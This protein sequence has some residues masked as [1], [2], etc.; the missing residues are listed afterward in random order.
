MACASR[1][2]LLAGASRSTPTSRLARVLRLH[3]NLP[4]RQREF[5][6]FITLCAAG[7]GGIATHANVVHAASEMHRT[8]GESLPSPG[9]YGVYGGCNPD[10][11]EGLFDLWVRLRG[12]IKPDST[13]QRCWWEHGCLILLGMSSITTTTTTSFPLNPHTQAKEPGIAHQSHGSS[14]Y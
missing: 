9:R 6:S 1:I 5:S 10:R 11:E 3:F 14:A 8:L 13:R 7:V 4:T 12:M 2:L